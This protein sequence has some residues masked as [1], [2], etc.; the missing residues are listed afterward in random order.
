ML[1]DWQRKGKNLKLHVTIKGRKKADQILFSAVS[2]VSS[3]V[4]KPVSGLRETRFI[5][6]I[7]DKN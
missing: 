1:I 3:L 5:K 4:G 6:T 2:E 7:K